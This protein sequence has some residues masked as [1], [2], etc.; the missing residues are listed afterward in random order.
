[1]A[2]D[3]DWTRVDARV[4]GQILAAQNLLFVLPDEARI[5]EFFSQAMARIPGVVS[6]SVLLG[7]SMAS[8][9]AT[10][11]ARREAEST[12]SGPLAIGIG[13]NDHAF[14]SFSFRTDRS[15]TF[16]PY[17]PFLSNLAN[18][19]AL[20]LENRLRKRQLE[21]SRDELEDEVERRT[22]EL[23]M[24]NERLE[25]EIKERIITEKALSEERNRSE[26]LNR[27]LEER[28]R[29]R[30][31]ELEAM[32]GELERMN[33]LFVGREL[34]MIELKGRIA[35]LGGGVAGGREP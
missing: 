26:K 11:E 1:M 15:G 10:G 34:R 29:G 27:E 4:L 22:G 13:T 25:E 5:A 2:G 23:R 24:A 17:M 35:E 12:A 14:G 30:T 9:G 16:E 18:Y 28:V 31:A 3:H 19:I 20:S 8:S 33:R 6:S 21:R 32:N 7:A